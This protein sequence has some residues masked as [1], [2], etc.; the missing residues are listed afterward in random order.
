MT[1]LLLSERSRL[2]FI[3]F[4]KQKLEN[5]RIIYF[6]INFMFIRKLAL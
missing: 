1:V 2:V 3:H 4:L 6:E 5:Q